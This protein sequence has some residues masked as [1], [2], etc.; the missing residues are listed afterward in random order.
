MSLFIIDIEADGPIPYKYS[1]LS[2]G[3]V[4]VSKTIEQCPTFYSTLKPIS[5]NWDEKA[6]AISGF[7]R[8][9]TLEFEDPK[10]VM[11]KF[12]DWIIANNKN[13]R[14]VF[15]SDNNGFDFAWINWYFHYFLNN[16][17][18]GWSSRRIGDLYSGLNNDW[19]AHWKQLR[20]LEH[21]HNALQDALANTTAFLEIIEKFNLN[22]S[23]K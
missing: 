21:T 15:I 11:Q 16:N 17:P 9:E 22:I 23:L 6:L 3:A 20:K 2:I 18:F 13:G 19:Y 1:M 7:S 4:K 10:I 8:E 14:P 12:N 5:D